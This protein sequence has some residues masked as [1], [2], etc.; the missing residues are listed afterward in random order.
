MGIQICNCLQSVSVYPVI[1]IWSPHLRDISTVLRLIL[2]RQKMN[3]P[4]F[5]ESSGAFMVLKKVGLL[6]MFILVKS[7]GR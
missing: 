3:L 2:F 5:Q 4:A 1:H 7:T 6:L